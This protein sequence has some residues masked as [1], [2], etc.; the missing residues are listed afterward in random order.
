MGILTNQGKHVMS[1]LKKIKEYPDYKK[2][3]PVII[4]GI[5]IFTDYIDYYF[6]TGDSRIA[7][8]LFIQTIMPIPGSMGNHDYMTLIINPNTITG[9]IFDTSYYDFNSTEIESVD[10]LGLDIGVFY[11]I[12]LRILEY[13][14]L[15]W[16]IP[17]RRYALRINDSLYIT[18]IKA[19]NCKN[20]TL[21]SLYSDLFA[22]STNK[23]ITCGTLSSLY[24]D[25]TIFYI[26]TMYLNAIG[27]G[28]DIYPEDLIIFFNDLLCERSLNNKPI[29]WL[30]S[31][32]RR[33][34][35]MDPYRYGQIVF[36][37]KTIKS[38]ISLI[39][40]NVHE[41]DNDSIAKRY[42]KEIDYKKP[43]S[44]NLIPETMA[45][46]IEELLTAFNSTFDLSHLYPE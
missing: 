30:S 9:V 34:K 14:C 21:F 29:D 26:P 3:P 22:P 28:L 25:I 38:Y 6:A 31:K 45:N 46:P 17:F 27:G 1:I 33:K 18:G 8:I 32:E 7:D 20:D 16:G 44:V 15:H 12:V 36:S 39:N 37:Q 43:A 40:N 11:K 10:T 35:L 41:I 2:H 19:L 5:D 4:S 13:G 42:W 23:P 24:D